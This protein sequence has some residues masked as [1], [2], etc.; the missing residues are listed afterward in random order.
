[1]AESVL[2]AV[3]VADDILLMLVKLFK[4]LDIYLTLF[5]FPTAHDHCNLPL[6]VGSNVKIT[7]T[8][9][10]PGRGAEFAILGGELMVA[11]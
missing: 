6:I 7:S 8:T 11:L 4:Q 5:L 10:L 3:F 2:L 1:M 9:S